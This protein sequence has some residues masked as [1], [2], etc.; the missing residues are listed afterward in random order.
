MIVVVKPNTKEEDIQRLIKM[1]ETQ[2]VK[3]HY[4]KGIDHTILGIVGDTTLVDV[5]K[6]RSNQIVENVLRVQ[7]PYK[8][9][10]R[11]FHPDDTIIDVKGRKV[12]EGTISIIA[13]PCSVESEEQIVSIAKS[14][15]QSGATFL[16]GGA[17]KPRSSPYA[18]QGMGYEGLDLLKIARKA[19]GLPIVSELMSLEQLPAFEDV[20]I[21]QVGARNMQ[22]FILLRELG[23]IDKPILL[24]RGLCATMQEFLM[25][26]EYIMKEGNDKVILCERGI[27]TFETATRNTLDLSCV[28]VLKKKSHLP[29]II[30]PSHGTGLSWTVEALS[31]AAIA[32]GADGVMI[33]VHNNPEEALCD[34]AQSITPAQF[35][36][37]MKT[38]KKYAE[39][40]NK[41][42]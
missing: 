12:G 2:G 9:A 13:G 20:D 21:I 28:P 33:E 37:I 8:K 14:V 24:K 22:N 30:D 26:A 5:A 7:E 16:R 41:V 18:F 40:E 4:S 32:V 19:T 25:S 6:I 27:R 31:K 34:G 38:L 36:S 10:N 15:K 1:I 29:I 42:M 17:F 23:K 11:L 39:I 35:D 3:I